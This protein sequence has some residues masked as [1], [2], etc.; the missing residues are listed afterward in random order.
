MIPLISPA[1]YSD[2][3][4]FTAER[5]RI[6]LRSWLFA[7]TTLDLPNH[8]DFRRIDVCG[9]S[10]VLQNFRG[11]I[12]AFNNVCTHRFARIHAEPSGNRPLKCPYHG[13]IYNAEGLPYAIP[14]KPLISEITPATL[15][16]Y[17]LSRWHVRT[18]GP[19]LFIK[20]EHPG[21]TLGADDFDTQLSD[22]ALPLAQLASACGE[23]VEHTDY[24]VAANWKLV[25]ENTLEGYH[26]DCVHPNTIAKLGMSGLTKATNGTPA[27]DGAPPK[28]SFFDF[29]GR[30]SAVFSPLNPEVSARMD[31]TYKFLAGRPQRL[32]GYRHYYFFPNF[33]IA[34]TRGESFSIQRVLPIDEKTTQL[35][36]FLFATNGLGELTKMEAA[37][38]KQFYQS[39]A[40][41]VREIF[42]ED[43]AICEEVQRGVGIAHTAGVLSDEEERIC[44]FHTA[45]RSA[46]GACAPDS[47]P[48]PKTHAAGCNG[49]NCSR[50]SAIP[51]TAPL[52]A[53]SH[54]H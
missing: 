48:A 43:A 47:V 29:A 2:P 6:F 31:R 3:A 22:Y 27:N 15:C 12:K 14:H 20:K 17:R 37:L 51:R 1:H 38:K 28:G 4:T 53:F 13:W 24:V 44:A 7:G 41:F 32:D 11:E 5:E 33:V 26:V 36:S 50:K 49:R 42:A 10:V 39:A 34:S 19:L 25:V 23:L 30:N 21:E 35:S 40:D 9:I 18:V 54:T 52:P 16:D 8:E 46:L 45:Y